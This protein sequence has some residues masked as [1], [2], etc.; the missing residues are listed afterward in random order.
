MSDKKKKPG[1]G[2]YK[3]GY[4][5]PPK[6]TQFKSGQSGNPTGRPKGSQNFHTVL[7]QEL[8]EKVT[9]N[10]NGIRKVVTKKEAVAK[11]YV[12]TAL[13]SGGKFR[14]KDF[15]EIVTA[16]EKKSAD[17]RAN[18]PIEMMT[19]EELMEIISAG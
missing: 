17:K 8:N 10:E 4:R 6:E 2:D 19:D 7:E 13:S 11:L 12:K 5:R 16:M 3:V 14:W 18:K 15:V 9:I 1:D